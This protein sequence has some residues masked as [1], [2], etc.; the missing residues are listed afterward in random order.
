VTGDTRLDRVM[1]IRD[2]NKTFPIIE[3]FS[4]NEDVMIFGSMRK[5]DINIVL[6]FVQLH[7]E[8]KFIIAP[9][10]I[11]ESMIRPLEETLESTM[12]YSKADS[13]DLTGNVLIIDNIG[14][15]S[16]VYRYAKFA[17]VGGGF[18]DGLHNILEPAVYEI[19]V[20]FGN[21]DYQRFKEA[22]D[23]IEHG[24]AFPVGS[25]NEFES[26]FQSIQ[27]DSDRQKEIK[28]NIRHYLDSNKGASAKI[29]ARLK[30][31]R[32]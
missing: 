28:T 3:S 29:I 19:P 17:Y 32:K 6:S 8:L 9:H 22:M 25:A 18:S 20:F 21:K 30:E 13:K 26:I 5:E 2:S 16:T 12:R 7:P 15:L 11:S 1:K 23:L 4:A 14:M 27:K 31:L 24:A 10:E